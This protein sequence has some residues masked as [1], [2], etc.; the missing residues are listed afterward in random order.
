MRLRATFSGDIR[1]P[2]I[3]ELYSGQ[4]QFVTNI[5]DP[6][7]N[8]NP[9]VPLLTG[10]NLDLT[11]EESKALTV[12]LVYQ[13]S[14]VDG[15][16]MSVDY[17]SFDITDAI[18]SLSGQQIV[19]GCFRRSQAI[20]CDAITLN[21]N[22]TISQV[23]ATLINA[24]EAAS[25]GVDVEVAYSLPVGADSVD[26]RLL[27]AYV[28]EL[29]TTINGVVTDVVRQL[30]SESAGGIPQWRFVT[31]ARYVRQ[32]FSAGVLVRYVDQGT[33]RNDYV[34][35]VDIDDN[36]IPS[37]TYVDL[38][39]AKNVNQNFE[40]YAKINNVFNVD[41]PLAP[42]QI[43]EPNY[44]SGSFHDRIGRYFKAGVRVQF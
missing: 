42:S 19:D 41:P 23:S 39:W 10:G 25:S 6:R 20:L 27:G 1:A 11:P 17:Y 16:R 7:D 9:T 30:G 5:I 33:Y 2:S 29:S 13:P 28:D 24:A 14:W 4:S 3:N 32:S 26:F 34:N 36:T 8:S 44:N 21:P 43:T 35:G 40:V 22:G 37:R 12:G 38:D 31:S 15:L 18:A